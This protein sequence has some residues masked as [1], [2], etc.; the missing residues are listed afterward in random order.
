M[1]E[2]TISGFKKIRQMNGRVIKKNSPMAADRIRQ[3]NGQGVEP[4][5]VIAFQAPVQAGSGIAGMNK[6]ADNMMEVVQTG[7]ETQARQDHKDFLERR[8]N[9]RDL[10]GD[11]GPVI[12]GGSFFPFS[13]RGLTDP[14]FQG[15][16]S[17][18]QIYAGPDESPLCRSGFCI[19]MKV[20]FHGQTIQ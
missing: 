10:V 15:K 2:F 9:G 6:T 17:R 12:D 7:S 18:V 4:G 11:M 16:F 14:Q 1:K 19:F 8:E 13:D 20:N 5:D 3:V